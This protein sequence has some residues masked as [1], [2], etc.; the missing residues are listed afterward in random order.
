M[1]RVQ[2]IERE[3]RSELPVNWN[4]SHLTLSDE[5]QSFFKEDPRLANLRVLVDQIM[6]TN[7]L[8]RIRVN[9]YKAAS[10][11]LI[12]K[13]MIFSNESD[14]IHEKLAVANLYIHGIVDGAFEGYRGKLATEVRKS[15]KVEEEE[16]ERDRRWS[17]LGGKGA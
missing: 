16:K 4:L 7:Y 9:Y 17:L 13:A 8:D 15:Y 11:S 1:E 10:D 3:V 14:P 2:Q 5:A 6:A 12:L